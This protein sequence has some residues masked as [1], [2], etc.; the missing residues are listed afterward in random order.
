LYWKFASLNISQFTNDLSYL[1]GNQ[2]ITLTGAVTGSGATTIATVYTTSTLFGF[3]SATAPITFSTSTGVIACPNCLTAAPATTSINGTQ[4]ANFFIVGTAGQVS[5]TVSGATTTFSLAS[6]S[7]TAGSYTLTNLTVDAYGRITAAS[8]GSAGGGTTTTI[9]NASGPAFTFTPAFSGSSFTIASATSGGSSTITFTIPKLLSAF[10]NDPG[11]LTTA[12]TSFNGSTSSTQNFTVIATGGATTTVA[13]SGGN[14][15]TT[16][17]VDAG[18]YLGID[19]SNRLTASST[20]ASSTIT[21]NI[22]DATTT[23]PYRFK[24]ACFSTNFTIT[25]ITGAEN[26]AATTTIQ[27]IRTANPATSTIDTLIA[28]STS[29]TPIS[30][31]T[32]SFA[33]TTFTPGTCLE[34]VVSSTVGTPTWTA[35]YIYGQKT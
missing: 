13:T 21:F 24:Q 14:S 1:T 8:N 12:I 29:F 34:A 16:V 22:Y 3:F 26:A 10:T 4:A 18:A 11:F 15:T 31:S 35:V 17:N 5:S 30:T 19:S 23:A 7:V 25:K 9:N 28:T 2:T 20:L 6:T 32:T 33:S 27:W